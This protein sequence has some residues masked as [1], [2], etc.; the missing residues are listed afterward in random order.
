ME[1]AMSK[2]WWR[3]N[4]TKK[5]IHWCTWSRLTFAKHCGGLVSVISLNLM[6]PFWLNRVGGYSP[7]L[8]VSLQG[9][10]SA[11][12]LIEKGI[13]WRISTG[14]NV[15]IWNEAWI[16]GDGDGRIRNQAINVNY[17]LVSDLI[18]DSTKT[19]K[20]NVL[21]DLFDEEQVSKICTIPLSKLGMRD[22]IIWRHDA[23]GSYT[24]KS[25][26]RLLHEDVPMVIGLNSSTISLTLSKFYFEMWVVNL[27][28]KVKI[29]MWKVI[30]N[31]LP[32][33]ANLQ[34]RRLNVINS[35]VFCHAASESVVHIM[36]DCWFVG[37]VLEM[38]G[39]QFPS[40]FVDVDW[41]EWL[42]LTF[43]SLSAK[44]RVALMVS[45]WAMW[46]APNKIIHEGVV[47]S[48]YGTLSFVETFIRENDAVNTPVCLRN[49]VVGVSWQAPMENVIKL[50]FDASFDVHC[51][52]S[53]SGVICRDNAG[54]IM[55]ACTTPHSHV[56][57][58]FLAE[59]LSCL[60][61]VKF[62]RDLGFS[63][64]IVEGDYLIVIKKVCSKMADVSLINPV[65]FDIREVAKGFADIAFCF[66]HREANSVVHTLAREGKLF[67]CPMFW[68]EETPPNATLA[69]ECD[70]EKL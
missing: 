36:R 21:N 66:T 13:G 67:N 48:V 1:Q 16:P 56:A 70:R 37:H 4:G 26:Y 63:R 35:C 11:R 3:N 24:V 10:W 58:A 6:W 46:Y 29:T 50:N 22:E 15:N 2:F 8:I 30:N 23:S 34:T 61:A 25:G 51:N 62:A 40:S 68:I 7:F 38:Q 31:S 19:W 65:I 17:T 20:L 45:Y 54:F 39:V 41:K 52:E 49:R 53:F 43:C 27:P 12:G 57:D 9:I 47:P 44:H 32:T 59:A 5:G 60:Q 33:L 64:V 28:A 69:A 55:A 14:Q 18:D 42:A